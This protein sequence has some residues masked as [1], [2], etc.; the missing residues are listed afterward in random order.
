MS[1][2]TINES[3]E[4]RYT[5]EE[6]DKKADVIYDA[7]ANG[8]LDFGEAIAAFYN[9]FNVGELYELY[10]LCQITDENPFGRSYDD[11]LFDA[12][13]CVADDKGKHLTDI[14]YDKIMDEMYTQPA[15]VFVNECKEAFANGDMAL[16]YEKWCKVNDVTWPDGISKANDRFKS[17]MFEIHS[18]CMDNF[19]DEEVYAI[20]D[21]GKHRAYSLAEQI[22]SAQDEKQEPTNTD[23]KVHQQ[24]L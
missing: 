16:A 5:P 13:D 22:S 15:M 2:F 19:T 9:E 20:T 21:Y 17:K 3:W 11:E 7:V 8:E 18:E 1:N 10:K 23:E 6:L 24:E 12:L 4:A 14:F